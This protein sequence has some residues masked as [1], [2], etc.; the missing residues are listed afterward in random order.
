MAGSKKWRAATDFEPN[1]KR[2]KIEQEAAL[3]KEQKR[4]EAEMRALEEKEALERDGM[5]WKP[6]RR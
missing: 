5:R 1:G 2:A 4:R 3:R 6:K